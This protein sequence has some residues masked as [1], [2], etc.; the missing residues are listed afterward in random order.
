MKR[1][2]E[3]GTNCERICEVSRSGVLI[4][5]RDY[6]LAV[7]AA[8][9]LA[10]RY[11]LIAGWQFDSA[12]PLVRGADLGLV[13]GPVRL[14]ELIEHVTKSNP[15][16][17]VYILAW[18][19][20]LVLALE[21]E[22]LQRFKF[23]WRTNDRIHFVFDDQHPVGASHHQKLVVVDQTIAFAG[24]ID[25]CDA[26]WDDPQHALDRPERITVKGEP[27]KPYHDLMAYSMGSA[28]GDLTRLFCARW[29]RATGQPLDLPEVGPGEPP[30][31]PNALPIECSEMAISVT[32]GAHPSSGT[33]K[34]EQIMHLHEQA[35]ARAEKLIYIETQYFTSH[36]IHDALCRR[37][38][39][40]AA[41][42]EVVLV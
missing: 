3:P 17:S 12:V 7:H 38:R 14:L 13:T 37:M 20:S 11:V 33:A 31:L 22:W 39:E 42:L 32:F 28:V 26:R 25:L 29:Q 27:Q 30:P 2:L 19:Y 36:A 1:I 34:C 18:D 4:D 41:G 23:D 16:L 10:Q 21:R 5:A 35:I 24:G 40:G 15:Q 9:Q 6:Y 8:L